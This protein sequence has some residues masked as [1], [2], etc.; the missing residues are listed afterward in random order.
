MF[1]APSSR[2]VKSVRTGFRIVHVLQDHDGATLND[3]AEQL[4]LAKSTVHNYLSTL[5]SMGYVVNQDG[6]YR[7]GLRFLTH[8]MAAKSGLQTRD[9]VDVALET[10]ADEI[11]QAVWWIA[12]EFGRGIFVENAVPADCR[13]I[14]GRTGKRSYLHTHAPGQAILAAL[15]PEDR[16]DVLEYHGLPVHT[17][18][19][20]DDRTTLRDRLEEI[21]EQGYAFSDGEAVLGVESVGVAFEAPGGRWN[22]LG[23]FG[24]AHDLGDERLDEDVSSLLQSAAAD[25]EATLQGTGADG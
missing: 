7:L 21:R 25:L 24:Y 23:V 2:H 4:D 13:R 5:E 20:I 9:A 18:R 6:T 14:Y 10:I 17:T 12:E 8:G 19:T 1:S 22:A 3:L 11:S 16:E 15:P